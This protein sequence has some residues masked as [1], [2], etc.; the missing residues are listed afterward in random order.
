MDALVLSSIPTLSLTFTPLWVEGSDMNVVG[1]K[2]R[3]SS[4][5]LVVEKDDFVLSRSIHDFHQKLTDFSRR[6]DKS[7]I[8]IK[9]LENTLEISLKRD[10]RGIFMHV[11]VTDLDSPLFSISMESKIENSH[12]GSMKEFFENATVEIPII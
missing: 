7:S 5:S 9:S 12:L 2:L 3:L 4:N 10:S 1:V 11:A 8:R 6:N